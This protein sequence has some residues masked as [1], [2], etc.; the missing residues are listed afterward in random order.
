M[1][2]SASA[3]FATVAANAPTIAAVATAANVVNGINQANAQNKAS[4]Q[5]AAALQQQQQ[6]EGE[7]LKAANSQQPTLEGLLQRSAK[8]STGGT[9]LTGPQGVSPTSL[10]LGKSTLL[11]GG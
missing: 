11:G 3:L 8:G 2:A 4:K 1:G 5:N 9:L 7:Q 6:V 10:T